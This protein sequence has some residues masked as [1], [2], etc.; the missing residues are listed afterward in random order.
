V[1]A[2]IGVGTGIAGIVIAND[3][4]D[5]NKKTDAALEAAIASENRGVA[6][7]EARAAKGLNQLGQKIED[8]AG[9]AN[10]KVQGEVAT[11]E[12]Q[13]Q[14]DGQ[15]SAGQLGSLQASV[16]ALQKQLSAFEATQRTT[17]QKLNARISALAQRVNSIGG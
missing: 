5:Q 4:R 3:A 2:V 1:V 16:A 10:E 14:A 15:K 11:A 13:I 12:K 8:E 6:R 7:Q 9:K 17:N